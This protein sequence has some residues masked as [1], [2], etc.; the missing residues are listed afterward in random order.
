MN[1]FWAGAALSVPIGICTNLVSP[2]VLRFVE[3]RNQRA[4]QKQQAERSERTEFAVEL[5]RDQPAF[6]SYLLNALLRT[7]YVGALFGILSGASA[8]VIGQTLP[9]FEGLFI[10]SSLFGLVG[11]ILV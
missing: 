5:A 7:A 4:A 6:Y 10:A 9:V 3:R 1:E 11:A 2:A 8:A